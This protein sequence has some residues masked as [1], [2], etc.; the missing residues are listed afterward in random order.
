MKKITIKYLSRFS[1]LTV[2]LGYLMEVI[3][4]EYSE[5][6]EVVFVKMIEPEAT[7]CKNEIEGFD[8]NIAQERFWF[9]EHNSGEMQRRSDLEERIIERGAK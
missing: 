8:F 4:Q 9:F 6:I 5:D 1:F 7:I 3:F 2:D